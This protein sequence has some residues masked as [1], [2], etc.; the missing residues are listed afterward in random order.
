MDH[1]EITKLKMSLAALSVYRN[2]LNDK[3]INNLYVLINLLSKKNYEIEDF[4]TYYADLFFVLASHN[5]NCS[6][7]EYL[8]NIILYDRNPFSTAAEIQEF[9]LINKQM[10]R[11][12]EIDLQ[13]LHKVY[14]ISSIDIKEYVRSSL[15]KPDNL[16]VL[17]DNLPDWNNQNQLLPCNIFNHDSDRCNLDKSLYDL[18]CFYRKNGTGIFARYKAFVWNH[19]ENS[20]YLKGIEHYDPVTFSDLIGYETERSEVINNTLQFLRGYPANN[21]LLYGDRGTGKSSTVK[22]LLNEYHNMGL[23]LI[24][25]PKPSLRDFPKMLGVL[26]GKPLKFIIFVDDLAFED[27][28]ESYLSLKALLEGSLEIKPPNA[29]IYA[30]SNRR[31]LIKEKFSDRFGLQSSNHDDEVRSSDIIQEKLS[32]SDRFGITIVFSSPDKTNYL[33]IVDKLVEKRGIK[34]DKEQLHKEALKWELWYNGRSPRTARQFVNWLEG[35]LA[36]N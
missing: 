16:A 24:E 36:S 18:A 1:S 28:K 26:R 19:T 27:S 6:L 9:R 10:L 35:Q 32:L 12:A 14:D 25:V 34:V 7:K 5:T 3:V 31:H 4:L 21:V 33:N 13:T 30:T 20:G 2:L 22:A 17:L 11:A 29:L 15:S 8:S 23:R